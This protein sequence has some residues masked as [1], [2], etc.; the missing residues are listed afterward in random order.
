MGAWRWGAVRPASEPGR[1]VAEPQGAVPPGRALAFSA[2][3]A[4]LRMRF[5]LP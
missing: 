4:W 1:A 3:P 5:L 2:V